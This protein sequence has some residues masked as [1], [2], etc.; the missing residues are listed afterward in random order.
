MMAKGEMKTNERSKKK[1]YNLIECAYPDIQDW[2]KET[3]IVMVPFGSCEQHGLHIP[4][5]CDSIEAWLATTMAAPKANVP[6]T[7]W[8]WMGYSPQHMRGP[9]RG[10]GT[11]TLRATTLQNVLYE[12]G[13]SLIHHGFNKLVYV[14]GHTS[15]L[16]VTDP[17][18]RQIRYDT[19]AFVSVFRA[20]SEGT[21]FIPEV[22]KILESPPEETPGWHGGELETSACLLYNEEL[23]HLDRYKD[24]EFTHPPKWLS[25]KFS[26]NNGDPYVVFKNYRGYQ[27]PMDHHEYS[28]T[29]MVGNCFR[30]S[31]EKGRKI[32]EI[33]SDYLAEFLKE[34][35]PLKLEVR[36]REFV[37][38]AF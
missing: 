1:V 36:N 13:R 33:I 16:K 20:D 14:M 2:L 30:G 27:I 32:F 35:K 10:M 24:K 28:D 9:N 38:R 31:K 19:G 15:L 12:V 5:G 4:V 22:A 34:I 26:K 8:I 25:K 17:V 21:Q 37:E 11:I 18:M 29:G 6:Y 3:D 23:V 7:P